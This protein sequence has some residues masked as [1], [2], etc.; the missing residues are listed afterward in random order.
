MA[1][2]CLALL[3]LAA[4]GPFLALC[5]A[6]TASADP[7]KAIP[8]SGPVPAFLR[9]GAQFSGPVVYV[10]DGDGLCVAVGE[11][12]GAWVEVRLADFYAA[13][14]GTS[15]GEL[16]RVTLIRI[17]KGRRVECVAGRRSYDRV[18]ALCR[19]DGVSIGDRMRAAGLTEGG[20]GF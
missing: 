12:P 20:R 11:G 9:P 1:P 17:A 15:G 19:L 14:Q 6:S 8:D 18:V 4:L 10:G 13:E 5:A 16:A 7:C 3:R 2:P